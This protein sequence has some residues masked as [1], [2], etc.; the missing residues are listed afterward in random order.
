M[1][2]FSFFAIAIVFTAI[3]FI[4]CSSDDSPAEFDSGVGYFPLTE[5]SWYEYE[6]DSIIF[7]D[8]DNSETLKQWDLRVEI[9]DT[10]TDGEGDE[11]IKLNRYLKPRNST[12]A[13]EFDRVWFVKLNNGRL[14]TFEDNLHFIKLI[15]PITA[16]KTWEGN[17]FINPQGN[18]NP[19][20]ST[21]F[22]NNW[23]YQYNTVG[24][25][26]T[27]QGENFS[28]V[29]HVRQVN[30]FG[31]PGAINHFVADEWYAKHVGLIKKR[32][33]I[34]VENCGADNCSEKNLP[35]LERSQLRK[36][37]ILNMELTNYQVAP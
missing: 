18:D 15:F 23:D 11:L 5:N 36:G 16:G 35:V 30:E 2:Q 13:Y 26:A 12:E 21:Q 6:L 3:I 10:I 31:G 17:Q 7:N 8:F 25:A 9:G 33:E 19:N 22:Y 4:S 27:V 34:V 28:E 1:K 20:T 24:E 29:T 37:F 14:E 32:M